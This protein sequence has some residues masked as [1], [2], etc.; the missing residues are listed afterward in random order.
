MPAEPE[1]VAA[2]GDELRPTMTEGYKAPEKKTLA[3]LQELDAEDERYDDGLLANETD[4]H[5]T[6]HVKTNDA[7]KNNVAVKQRDAC[8]VNDACLAL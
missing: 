4:V 8:I 7:C 6:Q 5:V 3:E 2:S 1:T